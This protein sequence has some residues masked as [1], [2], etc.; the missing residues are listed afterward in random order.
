ML[1]MRAIVL[2][3]QG[4]QAKISPIGGGCGHCDSVNG[5][6]SSKLSQ[7]SCSNQSRKF[8]VHNKAGAKVGDEVIVTL[9]KGILLHGTWRLYGLPL[10]L[11]LCG[12]LVGA[13]FA[14]ETASRDGF[15][16]LG[17]MFGL[18]SGFM[19]GQFCLVADIPKV[20]LRSIVVNNI[21]S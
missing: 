6:G 14:G 2:S 17:S 11:M 10:L 4:E 20:V 15:A 12:G 9:P 7:L 16:L 13:S 1:E 18:V 21:Q 8:V 5:C 3:V 19:L